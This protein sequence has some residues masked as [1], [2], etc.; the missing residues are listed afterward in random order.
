MHADGFIPRSQLPAE[1]VVGNTVVL[2]MDAIA[3]AGA[4]IASVPTGFN[5]HRSGAFGFIRKG[6]TW[7]KPYFPTPEA[8]AEI[9][10]TL[11]SNLSDTSLDNILWALAT[12][13]PSE[14][15]VKAYPYV[16]EY[17]YEPFPGMQPLQGPLSFRRLADFRADHLAS[18]E[19]SGQHKRE[20]ATLRI[21]FL[22]TSAY[23][24][25]EKH[26][27]VLVCERDGRICSPQESPDPS[28][29]IRAYTFNV[30]AGTYSVMPS[31]SFFDPA[32]FDPLEFQL[33]EGEVRQL[34]IHLWDR[35][36]T[37]TLQLRLPKKQLPVSTSNGE[38]LIGITIRSEDMPNY[39]YTKKYESPESFRILPGKY[40]ATV[41]YGKSVSDEAVFEIKSGE[42]TQ[43]EFVLAR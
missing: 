27:W 24:T 31:V 3:I 7:L 40:V 14:T 36:K 16:L 37:G 17:G 13:H 38:S 12:E 21:E 29:G 23:E 5:I 22:P 10:R 6:H 34:A 8:R 1:I 18:I 15:D 41:D 43:V 11:A 42:T 28:R 35:D 25:V 20:A 2:E 19:I 9:M 33:A 32:P 26:I 30:S 39:T 4:R